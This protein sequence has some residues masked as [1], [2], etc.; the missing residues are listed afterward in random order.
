MLHRPWRRK[1]AASAPS[2]LAMII[3]LEPRLE[4]LAERRFFSFARQMLDRQARDPG[5]IGS[6][7]EDET[8]RVSGLDD[9]K[10]QSDQYEACVRVLGDLAQLRWTLVESGYGLELHSPRPQDK[11]VSSSAQALRR[12]D[13]IRNE[14]LPRVLQQ[15][16]DPSVRKF[17][18][19]MER[20]PASSRRKSIRTL[21]ADGAELQGRLAAARR[22]PADH[23][24]RTAALGQAVRPYLQL[25][26]GGLRDDR[27]NIPLRDIWRY[28]RYT[29]SIPQTPIPGRSLLYL[30]RDAAHEAHAVIGIAALS[31]SAVQL[32]PRDRAIGWSA[33]GLEAALETLFAP[34]RERRRREAGDP[35]LRLHGV[36]RW[37]KAQLFVGVEPSPAAKAGGP[38]AR[39]RLAAAGRLDRHRR[40]RAPGARDGR[41]DRRADAAGRGA[42]APPQP[43]VRFPP[44]RGSGA[45]HGRR[46]RSWRVGDRLQGRTRR[47]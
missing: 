28:F 7:V 25:V 37:L 2:E 4:G 26:D 47:R 43:G 32:A 30:V 9:L 5:R 27:T 19:R 21:I 16:A 3:S 20:P 31:N 24:A 46:R 39:H 1:L 38:G 17:V 45:S 36:Y 12:K 8:T 44:A 34:P 15:F 22:H 13:A 29:W 33:A 40:D 14:L 18:H 6:L 41:G 35:A 11:R 10:G 42:P 23:P